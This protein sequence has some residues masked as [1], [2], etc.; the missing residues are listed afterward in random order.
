MCFEGE[1]CSNQGCIIVKSLA[2]NEN[3][4]HPAPVCSDSRRREISP[5]VLWRA[6]ARA[7]QPQIW[8]GAG[9]LP[10]NNHRRRG[11]RGGGVV[12]AKLHLLEPSTFIRKNNARHAFC[13]FWQRVLRSFVLLQSA[14]IRQ[15]RAARLHEM[16]IPS[17]PDI[18]RNMATKTPECWTTPHIWGNIFPLWYFFSSTDVKVY[19]KVWSSQDQF[20]SNTMIELKEIRIKASI[21]KSVSIRFGFN[22]PACDRQDVIS[23]A[24]LIQYQLSELKKPLITFIINHHTEKFL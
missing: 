19:S 21:S 9:S 7:G 17:P 24:H 2:P 18:N 1:L 15:S 12:V 13:Y 14:A 10:N 6:A 3:P 20:A 4:T 22:S 23:Y 8:A 16:M 11:W 5:F